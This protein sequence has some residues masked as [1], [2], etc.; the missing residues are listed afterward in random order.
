ME[1]PVSLCTFCLAGWERW[2]PDSCV[3]PCL[4]K[5]HFGEEGFKVLLWVLNVGFK[6]FHCLLFYQLMKNSNRL[7]NLLDICY[8]HQN[9]T[10]CWKTLRINCL[11]QWCTPSIP[12][13]GR[14]N[15]HSRAK[16]QVFHKAAKICLVER[17]DYPL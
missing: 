7:S 12:A 6:L 1:V 15:C 14:L 5:G 16:T 9:Q 10:P 4:G 3:I 11:A 17:L 8:S 2:L 13:L